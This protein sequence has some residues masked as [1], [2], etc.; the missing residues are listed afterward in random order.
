MEQGR[1]VPEWRERMQSEIKISKEEM[2]AVERVTNGYQVGYA[3]LYPNEGIDRQ[4]YVFDMTPENIANFIGSH[5]FDAQKIILTDMVDRLILDTA[6]GFIN[7]CPNQ[8]L[9]QQIVAKLAPIQMGETEPEDFP[10]VTREVYD[11]YAAKEDE[12]VTQAELTIM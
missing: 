8:E 11:R 3:Y 5:M 1:P 6:G 4:E 7:N 9:C 2:E 10:L 12:M